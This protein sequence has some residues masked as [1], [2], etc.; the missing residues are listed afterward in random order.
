MGTKFADR[1]VGVNE[2]A[3]LH[4]LDALSKGVVKPVP[5]FFVQIVPA[6]GEHLVDRN[7]IDNLTLGQVGGLVEDESAVV[8]LGLQGLHPGEV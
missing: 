2:L 7:E 1:R 5:L 8:D 4:L 6:T 3:C